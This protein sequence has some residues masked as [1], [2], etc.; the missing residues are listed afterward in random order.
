MEHLNFVPTYP[1]LGYVIAGSSLVGLPL[2]LVALLSNGGSTRTR[3]S[4]FVGLALAA[5][6]AALTLQKGNN[7]FVWHV[8]GMSL[9][10]FAFQPAALHCILAR[11]SF[12]DVETRT[13][14]V[15]QHKFLQLA[16]VS[17]ASAGFLAIYLNKP[18]GFP[19]KHFSSVHS[20]T[21]L[22]GLLLMGFNVAQAAYLQGSPLNPKLLWVSFFHRAAGT[23]ALLASLS[24]ATLGFYNRTPIVDWTAPEIR[25]SLPD[26]WKEMNGWAVSTHGSAL[27]WT[28]IG[29]TLFIMLVVLFPGEVA[30]IKTAKGKKK[31]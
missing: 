16:L 18:P 10:V 25:F 27:A 30:I 11:R 9:A 29:C 6:I 5:A 28:F 23:L 13:S 7:L 31:S 26:T 2:A 12:T 24:A 20:M 19:G 17:C 4:T 22:A 1:A 3:L 15:K 21:G 8:I 14:K